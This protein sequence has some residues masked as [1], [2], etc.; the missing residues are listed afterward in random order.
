MLAEAPAPATPLSGWI[1]TFYRTYKGKRLGPY[2]V[3]K[4]RVG[5]MIKRQYIKAKDLETI[6]A[7]C[8][9]NKESRQQKV[10][11]RHRIVRSV[12][13]FNF[14]S[15]MMERMEKGRPLHFVQKE[16]IVRIVQRIRAGDTTI[17]TPEKPRL[18]IRVSRPHFSRQ[19]LIN[20]MDQIGRQVADE[21]FGRND[22]MGAI[23]A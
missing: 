19:D 17:Y 4:W 18:R 12:E 1:D 8:Q 3:R 15:T 10:E 20:A 6:R 21:I 7:A 23:N 11:A 22:F 5:K 16:H 9:A 14:L 13:N 2:H